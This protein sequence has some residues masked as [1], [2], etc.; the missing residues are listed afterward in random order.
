MVRITCKEQ[1][2]PG[3]TFIRAA[4]WAATGWLITASATHAEDAGV[5]PTF[6]GAFFYSRSA[7][8]DGIIRIEWFGSCL[9]WLLL[10]LS[11]IGIGYLVKLATS[12]VRK[13]IAPPEHMDRIEKL[14]RQS[15]WRDALALT[16]KDHSDFSL[17]THATLEE[18]PNGFEAMASRMELVASEVTAERFRQIEPLNVLGQV[19]PMIGLFGTVYG[20]I[21]AFGSIVAS[22]GNA[23]PVALAGGIGTALVTTF[24]GLLVAIPALAGYAMLRNRVDALEGEAE[25]RILEF[26]EH[27]DPKKKSPG[28]PPRESDS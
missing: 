25:G 26:L 27:F 13:H 24:W 6:G 21:V 15:A 5:D 7:G 4:C 10:L 17:I 22:G 3:A 20:M 1:C 8:P 9:I 18:A 19:A 28:E 16:S 11:I 14:I 23:D 2:R 12:N